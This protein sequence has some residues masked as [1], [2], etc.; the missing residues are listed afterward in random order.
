MFDGYGFERENM[1]SV[2]MEIYSQQMKV[3]FPDSVHYQYFSDNKFDNNI[4]NK[5]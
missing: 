2:H 3:I 4:M 5:C 1:I